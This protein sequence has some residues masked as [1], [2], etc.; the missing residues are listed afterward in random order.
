MSYMNFT[1]EQ[2]KQTKAG[3]SEQNARTL[4]GLQAQVA[5]PARR[6]Q[7]EDC[8]LVESKEGMAYRISLIVV[9]RRRMDGH[10]NLRTALKPIVDSITESLGFKS[11]DDPRLSWRYN[12]ISGGRDSD[13]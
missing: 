8:Q 5:K 11:D 10:D 4:A 1:L 9:S 6:R 12:Q 7:S 2:L 3:Q 13:N